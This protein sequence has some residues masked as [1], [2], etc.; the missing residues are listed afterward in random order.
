MV[1]DLFNNPESIEYLGLQAGGGR[2]RWS[3]KDNRSDVIAV[4]DLLYAIAS[5]TGKDCLVAFIGASSAGHVANLEQVR[6]MFASL[7][8]TEKDAFSLMASKH[9]TVLEADL[10][11]RA[12]G[13][14]AL[15]KARDYAI[16]PWQTRGQR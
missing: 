10:F 4:I 3:F 13:A 11:V 16:D 14:E 12:F 1:V 8:E 6:A 5:P 15:E 9:P 2:A 7:S